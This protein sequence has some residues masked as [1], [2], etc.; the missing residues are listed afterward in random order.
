MPKAIQEGRGRARS[1]RNAS[2]EGLIAE[3]NKQ[4]VLYSQARL[5]SRHQTL[6]NLAVYLKAIS[7]NQP[8]DQSVEAICERDRLAVQIHILGQ[9]SRGLPRILDFSGSMRPLMIM[10][11]VYV[12][13]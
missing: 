8:S 6:V 10:R 4:P 3:I 13:L 9:T 2:N 12:S 11:A 1:R 5:I 7:Q